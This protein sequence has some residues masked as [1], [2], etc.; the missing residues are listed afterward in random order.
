MTRHSPTCAKVVT[1]AVKRRF[2]A[3]CSE[4]AESTIKSTVRVVTVS[5]K[6]NFTIN[7]FQKGHF[8]RDRAKIKKRNGWFNESKGW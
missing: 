8:K 2:Y 5:F 6:Y 1:T 7:I 3:S 4:Q